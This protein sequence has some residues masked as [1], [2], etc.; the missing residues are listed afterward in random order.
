MQVPTRDFYNL[1]E[2]EETE[3]T[4]EEMLEYLP[5]D[6]R[7][8]VILHDFEV[9]LASYPELVKPDA[10]TDL[11]PTQ[12]WVSTVLHTPVYRRQESYPY[13]FH[14]FLDQPQKQ[15]GISYLLC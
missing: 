12:M 6:L 3:L 14:Y 8:F 10:D 7:P 2:V 15:Q 9:D 5:I 1:M 13:F 4:R 11:H